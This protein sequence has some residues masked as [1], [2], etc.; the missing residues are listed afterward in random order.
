MNEGVIEWMNEPM[1]KWINKS[2]NI[3]MNEWR[4]EGMEMN[5]ILRP[6]FCTLATPLLLLLWTS[7]FSILVNY[8]L[9]YV[10]GKIDWGWNI[11]TPIFN[12]HVYLMKCEWMNE[13]R[14]EGMNEWC[15]K[16]TILHYKAILGQRQPGLM[17]WIVIESCPRCSIHHSTCWPAVQCTTTVLRLPA[18]TS[19][20]Y[21]YIFIIHYYIFIFIINCYQNNYLHINT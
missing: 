3:W 11:N 10:M 21:I 14:K 18:S 20:L 6:N 4:S 19:V 5:H 8:N 9:F 12:C 7:I 17:R 15:F 2:I 1:M 16:V 13:W